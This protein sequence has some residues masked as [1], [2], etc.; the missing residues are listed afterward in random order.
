MAKTKIGRPLK[1][2]ADEKTLSTLSGLAR[3]QC[4]TKEAASVLDV[5]EPTFIAFLK[6]NKKAR[7]VWDT[8]QDSG[9]ASIRR[10]QYRAAE[11][12]NTTMQIWLGKQYLGQKD[13]HD[14]NAKHSADGSFLTMWK[15][16]SSGQVEAPQ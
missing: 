1:L 3:I 2:N 13:R 9:R 11:S 4:T 8:G 12:G 16:L 14:V 15:A 7:E 5:S 10:M 6:R